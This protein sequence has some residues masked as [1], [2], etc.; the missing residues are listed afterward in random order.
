MFSTWERFLINSLLQNLEVH[1]CPYISPPLVPILNKIYLISRT[2]T[3]V[4]QI[5]FNIYVSASLKVS[6]LQVPPLKLCLH[7]WIA[8]CPAHLSRFNLRFL[9]MLGVE[10]NACSSA[11]CNFLHSP[12]ISSLLAQNIFLSSLFSN[13]LNLCSSLNVRDQVSQPYNTTGNTIVITEWMAELRDLVEVL[14]QY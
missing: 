2:T 4:P 6:F 1:Y 7:F 10:Y 3:F 5:H 11:L 8:T 14:I 9:I 13:T 12:V